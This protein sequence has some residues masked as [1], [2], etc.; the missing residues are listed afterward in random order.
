MRG[1]GSLL[2]TLRPA[3]PTVNRWRVSTSGQVLPLAV[4]LLILTVPLLLGVLG[5]SAAYLARDKAQAAADAAALAA[6]DQA[7]PWESLTVGS[8]PYICQ[9]EG[10]GLLRCSDGP[11]SWLN[12]LHTSEPL[13]FASGSSGLPGWAELAGCQA[14]G[15]DPAD[16]LG[17]STPMTV[18]EGWRLLAGGF[19][20]AY[21]FG[22][23]AGTHPRAA[24]AAYLQQ[25]TE[26]LQAG[27]AS[28][29]LVA[30][31]ADDYTGQVEIS[32]QVTEP[33]NPLAALAAR[34]TVVS[35]EAGARRS[36]YLPV[37]AGP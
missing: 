22:F 34:P 4:I 37:A 30:F 23:P 1:R 14:V 25:N 36:V 17:S 16:R 20:A 6:A 10:G 31:Q 28:V 29:K 33:N 32:V 15:S 8:H 35:V 7:I 11:T 18:C 27:G 26:G 3:W 21:G 9:T 24:A 5:A 13:L 12:L 19:G 2:T